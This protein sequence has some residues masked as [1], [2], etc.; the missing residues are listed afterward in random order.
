MPKPDHSP[1]LV[2]PERI[3]LRRTKGW[4]KP[5]GA[6]VVARPTKWG[7]PWRIGEE[8]IPDAAEAVRRF[9]AATEGFMSNGSFCKPQA[10]PESHIGR[11]IRDIAQLRG[12]DLA[13]WCPIGQ[14]CHA[15]VLIRLANLPKPTLEKTR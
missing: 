14:P 15:D 8:G 1:D 2:L 7:N 6:V 5:A 3:Q 13:C 10:H 9:S 11:I 4:Q 12:H